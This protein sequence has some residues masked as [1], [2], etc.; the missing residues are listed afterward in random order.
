D[1][2]KPLSSDIR[3]NKKR[4]ELIQRA[5]QTATG[6]RE[7]MVAILMI[8]QYREFIPQDAPVSHAIV[9][10]LLNLDGR[11]H[12]QIFH[13]ACKNIGHMPASIA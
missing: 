6:S 1:A 5:L 11:I 9:D 8:R 10:A 13:D 7:V 2:I 12:I 4:P 3:R